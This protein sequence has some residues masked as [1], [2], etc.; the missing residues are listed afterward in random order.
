MIL[1]NNH[2]TCVKIISNKLVRKSNQA[3]Q[4]RMLPRTEDLGVST[5]MTNNAMIYQTATLRSL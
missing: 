4:I 2:C 3:W 5:R 1:P